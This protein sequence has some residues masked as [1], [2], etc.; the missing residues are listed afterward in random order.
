[1]KQGSAER[2]NAVI[3]IFGNEYEIRSSQCEVGDVRKCVGGGGGGKYTMS[4]SSVETR[5]RVSLLLTN[6]FDDVFYCT[7]LS[8]QLCDRP[9]YIAH[10]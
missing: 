4:R 2:R 1:M 9:V 8:A 3:V 7:E 5:F 10:I 6:G